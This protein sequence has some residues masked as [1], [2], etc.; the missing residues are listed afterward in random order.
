MLGFARDYNKWVAVESEKVNM[1]NES[2]DKKMPLVYR[3][4]PI[5]PFIKIQS[6]LVLVNPA[7]TNNLISK[8]SKVLGFIS[9]NLYYYTTDTS[10]TQAINTA[11]SFKHLGQT[12]LRILPMYYDPDIVNRQI[13]MKNKPVIDKRCFKIG[14]SLYNSNL[15]QL[16]LLEFIN[17]FNQQKNIKL[18]KIL[19][20]KLMGNLNKDFDDLMCDIS[21]L[22]VDC[23]DYGKIKS[24]ICEYVNNHHDKKILFAEIDDSS[25]K[26][27]RKLLEKI[28]QLPSDKLYGELKTI[29]KKFVEYGDVK[30][31]GDFEFP[32]MYIACQLLENKSF[33]QSYCKNKKF[34]IDKKELDDLLKIMT[35]DILN[36]VKSK[37]LFNDILSDNV[38]NFF[39]FLRRVDEHILVSV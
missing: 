5:Y 13:F 32:N 37:W 7:A 26:F 14:K 12:K 17:V 25:Y 36:P 15:Y 29:S 2:V 22:I 11:S 38:L 9:N 20:K 6:W 34:I 16:L 1:V 4:Q 3:V 19:R 30:K 27:D 23:D 10:L 31:L 33:S 24:Q 39:K 21:D 35:A 28:K 8:K 18:R